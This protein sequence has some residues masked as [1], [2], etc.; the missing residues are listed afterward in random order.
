MKRFLLVVAGLLILASS[1]SAVTFSA[2]FSDKRVYH[3]GSE[4]QIKLTLVND[5]SQTFRCKLADERV[6]SVD[7]DVRSLSNRQLPHS[8][9]F[10]RKRSQYQPT[11]FREI[12]IE[13]GEEYSFVENLANYVDITETGSY[14]VSCLFYPELFEPNAPSM[15]LK[16]NA[17][18][19]SVRPG[20]DVPDAQ[21]F[22]DPDS[23]EVLQRESLAPDQVIDY[24]LKARQRGQWDKFFL[25]FDLEGFLEQDSARKRKYDRASDSERQKMVEDLKAGL[26]TSTYQISMVPVDY[27]ILKTSYTGKEAEVRVREKFEDKSRKNGYREIKDYTYHLWKRDG[28]W[29]VYDYSVVNVGVE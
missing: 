28:V 11:Y 7:F 27:E 21:A 20:T 19:L 13:P 17:L 9:R 26:R 24:M 25:Y 16:S 18:S 29:Y 22:T 10:S 3:P 1:A 4:V 6:F 8:E 14:V 12:A 2:K 15:A 23:G 5:S